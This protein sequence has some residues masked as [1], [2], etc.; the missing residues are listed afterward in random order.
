[1]KTRCSTTKCL[2]DFNQT[3]SL[4]VVEAVQAVQADKVLVD[5]HKQTFLSPLVSQGVQ[6]LLAVQEPRVLQYAHLYLLPQ[7]D[8]QL[9]VILYDQGAQFDLSLQADQFDLVV[10][11]LQVNQDGLFPH[12]YQVF[13]GGLQYTVLHHPL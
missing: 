4:L 5:I 1:M 11:V 6:V 2:I 8:R 12:P 10:P 9:Q 3:L 13:L 7:S